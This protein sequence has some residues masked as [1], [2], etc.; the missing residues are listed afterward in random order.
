MTDFFII[1]PMLVFGP[2]FLYLKFYDLF[3]GIVSSFIFWI[4]VVWRPK[5]LTKRRLKNNLDRSYHDFRKNVISYIF[6]E[7]NTEYSPDDL[8]NFKTF[9]ELDVLKNGKWYDVMNYLQ[10]NEEIVHDIHVEI[11]ILRDELSQV[12]NNLDIQKKSYDTFKFFVHYCDR[13]KNL[14]LLN[15]DVK[16]LCYFLYDILANN[17]QSYGLKEKDDLEVAIKSI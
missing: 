15:N 1:M 10:D 13:L 11:Q 16:Y 5:Q 6:R 9:R 14:N 12:L 3:I 8:V 7:L 17:S 2:L 4:I